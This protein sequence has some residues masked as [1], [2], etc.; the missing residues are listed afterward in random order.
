MLETLKSD[1]LALNLIHFGWYI[2]K[3]IVWNNVW[4]K[5]INNQDQSIK[6]SSYITYHIENSESFPSVNNFLIW[7]SIRCF[8]IIWALTSFLVFL[9]TFDIIIGVLFWEE[10]DVH[11]QVIICLNCVSLQIVRRLIPSL[12][13]KFLFIHKSCLI[14][15][16]FF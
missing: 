9:N 2:N 16:W 5:D 15:Y 12:R 6:E 11:E 13:V 8:V 7:K 10:F 14:K 3:H 1:V 4:Y